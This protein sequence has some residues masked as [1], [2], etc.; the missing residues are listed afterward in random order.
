[1]IA[2][3][4]LSLLAATVSMGMGA[5]VFALYAHTVMP[6]LARTD[7][8]TFVAA[9]G[10]M[11]RSILNVWFIGGSFFGALV[12]GAVAGA[13]SLGRPELPWIAAA[14]LLWAIAVVITIAVNVPLN[15]ALKAAGP[16]DSMADPAAV[17]AAFQEARWRAWNLVRVVLCTGAFALVA[18]ALVVQGRTAG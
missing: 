8:R 10:S 2:L 1:M 7:D 15:N 5:G 3:R 17:R 13:L 9:F 12:L 11:D 18:W 16:V 14:V 4:T 6:G